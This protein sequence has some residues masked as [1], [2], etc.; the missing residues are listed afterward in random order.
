MNTLRGRTVALLAAFA[1]AAMTIAIAGCGGGS[2]DVGS[3][4]RDAFHP[5]R[6]IR[7]G[8]IDLSF[9]LSAV[10][11][12]SVRQPFALRV[13]GPF[14]STG[15][16]QLPRFSLAVM[17][18]GGGR[19]VDV[20]ATATGSQLFV[21]LQGVP[22]LAPASV[23]QQVKQGYAQSS[24][25]AAA[26]KT[27]G[28]F[29]SLGID[30]NRW[31][32]LPRRVGISQVGGTQSVHVTAGLDV[33]R[34]LADL[35]RVSSTGSSLGLGGGLSAAQRAAIARSVS[36]SRVD[37][38]AGR[39]DHALRRLNVHAVLT[40]PASARAALGGLRSGTLDFT[41]GFSDVNRPQAIA[42]P[43]NAQPLSKLAGALGQLSG[44]TTTGS[45]TGATGSTGS[46]G[47]G[48]QQAYLQCVQ[49]AGQDV[50]AMQRCGALLSGG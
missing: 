34:F 10:G 38:Y 25:T 6:P 1:A 44:L 14:Q 3:V 21:V 49:Q 30:P 18:N 37:V 48:G 35:A 9:G 42:A 22:Y 47:V 24:A 41:L 32:I 11:L 15:G 2:G 29:A 7:S 23:Y 4:L 13:Q 43:A 33:P 50:R 27:P 20:G 19:S 28:T 46:T 26:R 5:Q 17:L 36:A 31:L 45:T 39:A 12:A 40:P 8:R 16:G